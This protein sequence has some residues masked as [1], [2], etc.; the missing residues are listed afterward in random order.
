MTYE[1]CPDDQLIHPATLRAYK[2]AW[3]PADE[4]DDTELARRLQQKIAHLASVGRWHSTYSVI[5]KRH[6]STETR[7]E[8]RAVEM[9]DGVRAAL[10]FAL[11][12]LDE[13]WHEVWDEHWSVGGTTSTMP[14][15]GRR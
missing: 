2:Q 5:L 13:A 15:F 3:R 10:L 6:L 4:L 8:I 1:L 11:K 7:Q 12:K 9:R 14:T